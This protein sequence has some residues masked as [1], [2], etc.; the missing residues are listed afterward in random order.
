[1]IL[2]THREEGLRVTGKLLSCNREVTDL[3]LEKQ[4][5]AEKQI[6]LRTINLCG[7]TFS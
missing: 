5:P 6:R 2:P 3:S 7:R 1:M 4:S